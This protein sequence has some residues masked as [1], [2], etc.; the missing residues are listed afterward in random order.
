MD[1][2]NRAGGSEWV[3]GSCLCDRVR[4]EV[5]RPVPDLYRC[6]CSLCR[7]RAV[8]PAM[9]PRWYRL[10]PSAGRA[11]TR[12]SRAGRSRPVSTRISA[13]AAGARSRIH[14]VTGR[15]CGCLRVSST[16]PT[17]RGSRWNSATPLA[18]PGTMPARRVARSSTKSRISTPWS[19]CCGG[20][21]AQR[22]LLDAQFRG[23][24]LAEAPCTHARQ[25]PLAPRS[26]LPPIASA[27]RTSTA[28]DHPEPPEFAVAFGRACSD[29]GFRSARPTRERR[30]DVDSDRGRTPVFR[31]V[32]TEC[33]SRPARAPGHRAGHRN[34][35]RRMRRVA[36]ACAGC[37][38]G[39]SPVTGTK[40]AIRSARTGAWLTGSMCE[41]PATSSN[42][43]FG[44]FPA[45]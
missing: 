30:R 6:H 19:R 8:R 15:G 13:A 1:T 24:T 17:A 35:T 20:A 32:F 28:S 38:Q 2:E 25:H 7:R 44:I 21:P 11:A 42:A 41:P 31:W 10:T 16:M 39:Y 9:R 4:F 36:R 23:E 26:A 33:R 40:S 14:S 37:L 34:P 12:R 18:R 43:A 3:S 45:R 22:P 27:E 5:R 29:G